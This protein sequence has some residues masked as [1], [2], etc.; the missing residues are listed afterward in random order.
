MI[1]D[2][3]VSWGLYFVFLMFGGVLIWIDQSTG[4]AFSP[5]LILLII[6]WMLSR[7]F[8]KHHKDVSNS[9]ARLPVF[10]TGIYVVFVVLFYFSYFFN[11]HWLEERWFIA[12]LFFTAFI[13]ILAWTITK[14]YLYYKKTWREQG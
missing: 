8:K 11:R 13:N 3:L 7:L 5:I 4:F 2:E 9:W 14:F 1:K 6:L 12:F 10:T